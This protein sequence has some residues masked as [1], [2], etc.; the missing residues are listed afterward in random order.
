MK[1]EEYECVKAKRRA[2]V[3]IY[4]QTKDLTPEQLVAHYQRLGDA[5]RKRQTE[6]RARAR[7]VA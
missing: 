4:E 1:L 5:A 3:R 2:Q 7:P 6:L